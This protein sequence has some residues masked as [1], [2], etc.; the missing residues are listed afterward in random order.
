[1]EATDGSDT[2]FYIHTVGVDQDRRLRLLE[3]ERIAVRGLQV[4]NTPRTA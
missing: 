4:G 2:Y 3:P 1:M